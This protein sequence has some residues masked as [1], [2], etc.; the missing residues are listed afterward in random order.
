MGKMP[1]TKIGDDQCKNYFSKFGGN[2]CFHV[3]GFIRVKPVLPVWPLI[4]QLEFYSD[5]DL[6]RIMEKMN[7]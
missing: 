3:G 1:V 5:S 7:L 2:K 4:K 6:E